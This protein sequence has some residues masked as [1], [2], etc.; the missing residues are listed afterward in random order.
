M[1]YPTIIMDDFFSDPKKIKDFSSNL[2]FG[3]DSLGR[4]PGERTVPLHQIDFD[5]FEYVHRKILSILYPNDF[6]SLAF[7]ADS[8]FQKVSSKRHLNPGWIHEDDAEITAIIYLSKHR[9]CGTTLWTKKNFYNSNSTAKNKHKFN[10]KDR[11]QKEEIEAVNLHNNNFKK[12]LEV[13][14]VYNRVLMFDSNQHHSAS[15][16]LDKDVKEDRLTLI[17]FI[18][19]IVME[20][21]ALR[22]PVPE[23]RRLDK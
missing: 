1:I 6:K 5:F 2:K 21:G 11:H 20:N 8:Y 13:D 15:N 14:S 22:Y 3:K 17:T 4:W 23:C 19:R 18:R 7:N 10:L 12:N 16:F 9:N